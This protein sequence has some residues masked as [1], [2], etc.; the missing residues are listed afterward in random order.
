MQV[1]R[2]TLQIFLTSNC[3]E[4]EL[5][6]KGFL[7]SKRNLKKDNVIDF[8]MKKLEIVNNHQMFNDVSTYNTFI[9]VND[10]VIII[11]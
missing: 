4:L 6:R 9:N 10:S 8:L 1:H 3:S 11:V 5:K 2:N 7:L